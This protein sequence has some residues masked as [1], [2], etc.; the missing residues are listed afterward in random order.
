[1]PRV[2]QIVGFADI[3]ASLLQLATL[4]GNDKRPSWK[5]DT[6]PWGRYSTVGEAMHV[7]STLFISSQE[8]ENID[9]MAL[10]AVSDFARAGCSRL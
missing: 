4:R 8:R 1:M 5:L 10:K 2:H 9:F 6:C 7:L 3:R